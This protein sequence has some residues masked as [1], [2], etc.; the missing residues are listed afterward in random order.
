MCPESWQPQSN[1]NPNSHQSVSISSC[2]A[3]KCCHLFYRTGFNYTQL[4]DFTGRSIYTEAAA[5]WKYQGTA[6][7]KA[8]LP[9]KIGL[10][11]INAISC[12]DFGNKFYANC[13]RKLLQRALV[14]GKWGK[15]A[16]SGAIVN[17]SC[18]PGCQSVDSATLSCC[19]V[20]VELLLL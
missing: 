10:P 11:L 8:H 18:S 3:T 13:K 15:V 12:V 5:G 9:P 2:L 17:Q 19:S 4:P 1:H 6:T 14:G 20:L 16:A 7:G